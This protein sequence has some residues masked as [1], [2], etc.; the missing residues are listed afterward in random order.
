MEARDLKQLT[1]SQETKI[2]TVAIANLYH[3]RFKRIDNDTAETLMDYFQV[4]IGDLFYRVKD[5]E[6]S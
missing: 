3:N 5:P 6:A 1:L 4:D 2:G